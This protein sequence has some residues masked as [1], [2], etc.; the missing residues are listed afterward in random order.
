VT[1]PAALLDSNVVIALLAEEHEHH[2][3]SLALLLAP[4]RPGYAVA[5]HSYA[6]AYA[7]L[8]RPGPSGPFRL[9][10]AVAWSA[11]ESIRAATSLVG[12]TPAQVFDAVRS[13]AGNGGVGPR[14]YD[15]LIGAA[16]VVHGIPAIVTWITRHLSGLFPEIDVLSPI[17]FLA[18]R[19]KPP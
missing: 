17:R 3:A 9:P 18:A 5:A 10:P 11:L 6:E 7:T 1:P 19:P 2:A 14:L 16:A 8:T 12:L 4:N 13:Y 15:A